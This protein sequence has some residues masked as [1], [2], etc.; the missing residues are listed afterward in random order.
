MDLGGAAAPKLSCR[1]CHRE[2]TD[3]RNAEKQEATANDRGVPAAEVDSAVRSSS[4]DSGHALGGS[5]DGPDNAA[6]QELCASDQRV[7]DPFDLRIAD[8]FLF[9]LLCRD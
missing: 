7:G 1:R 9:K 2:R 5:S 4:R 8:G 6:L 3:S